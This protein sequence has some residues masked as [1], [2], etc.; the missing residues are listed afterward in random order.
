M[1]DLM[2]VS[3]IHFYD[4]STHGILCGVRGAEHR[5]TK[6][7]RGVTC[8]ACVGLLADRPLRDAGAAPEAAAGRLS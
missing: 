3:V 7:A 2:A 8:S 1:S 4:T 5:S 6:H